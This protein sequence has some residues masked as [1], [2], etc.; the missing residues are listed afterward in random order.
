MSF[1]QVPLPR[2]ALPA[3]SVVAESRTRFSPTPWSAATVAI[4][5]KGNGLYSY[6]GRTARNWGA[7][8]LRTQL[9]PLLQCAGTL[10]FR[11]IFRAWTCDTLDSWLIWRLQLLL[12]LIT[13]WNS[14]G[15]AAFLLKYPSHSAQNPQPGYGPVL[16][17]REMETSYPETW[18]MLLMLNLGFPVAESVFFT[19]P[20]NA[21]GIS[22]PVWGSPVKKDIKTEF[23]GGSLRQLGNSSLWHMG[24]GCENGACPDIRWEGMGRPYCCLQWEGTEKIEPDFFRRCTV[25]GE[26][27]QGRTWKIQTWYGKSFFIIRVTK[28]WNG[29]QRS[30]E[31]SLLGDTQN[32]A[33][34]SHK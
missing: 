31:I 22:C 14:G 23:S 17:A 6:T 8:E 30:F 12:F 10:A 7:S 34:Q 25:G 33:G 18:G 19:H 4:L 3:L 2:Q 29:A 9:L 15:V 16:P 32:S 21:S 27:A 5:Q 28:D 11:R 24:R 20:N 26:E 13:C 1:L